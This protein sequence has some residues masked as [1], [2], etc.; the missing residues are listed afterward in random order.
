MQ[1][2]DVTPHAASNDAK[3]AGLADWDAFLDRVWLLEVSD[4]K[5]IRDVLAEGQARIAEAFRQDESIA[6]LVRARCEMVDTV[7][8]HAW[9]E[10][11]ATD[12][13]CLVAVG[14]YGRHELLP[15]SDIDLLVLYRDGQLENIGPDLEAFF[16]YLWDL[17]LQIGHSV[18]TPT[19]CRQR[20]TDD[21]TI[22]T[23]LMESRV[24]AGD[25]A[26][27]AHMR[28]ATSAEHI[29]PSADFFSAKTEEQNARHAHYDETAYKLEPNVKESPGGLRD[30]QTIAW[31]AKRQ[32]SAHTL[33]GLVD[34]GF[35]SRR[36]FS[37]LHEGQAFLWR[38]RF[39]LHLLT[40]RNE[41]RLLFD[42]QIQV[43]HL[44]GYD[45]AEN[46][47]SVERFM[48]SYY[49][50]IKSLSALN[51]V[52][53]QLF[54]EAILHADDKAYPRPLNERFQAR[55][56]FIEVVHD[57]IFVE[58]PSA[59]LEIFYLMQIHPE[60]GG[61][62]ARTLRLMRRDRH[63]IDNNFI[64][65]TNCNNLFIQIL[66]QNSGVTRALRRMNRYGILG[67]YLPN[68]GQ[69]IG[70]MQYDLLH[71][72][73]VDEHTLF[74]IRNMRR[75]ALPR[76]NH[77]MPFASTLMQSLKKPHILYIVALMHDIAKG[78][79]GD[80]AQLGA[81]D[82]KAFCAAHD[83]SPE[84]TDLIC[85]LVRQHLLMSMTAQRRD[86]SNVE[87]INQFAC[88]VGSRARLDRLYLL[89]IC[90]I[91]ATNPD[92]WNSWKDSLLTALYNNARRALD[93]GLDDPL[94]R[95]ELIAETRSA[96]AAL[97]TRNGVRTS[98]F[99]ALWERFEPE[100]FLR[101]SAD[102]IAR[103]T[104][105]I[106]EHG[107]NGPLVSIHDIPDQGTA[108]SVYCRDRN[109]LFG[110]TTGILAQLGFSIMDARINTTNDDYTLDTYIIAE[111]DGRPVEDSYRRREIESAL[112]NAIM[113]PA[114]ESIDVS[115][116]QGRRNQYFDV[117]T[118][119]HF[120]QATQHDRTVME[121][122]T[123]DRPG[124][125][126]II[127]DVFYRFGILIK[128]AKIATVGERV[129]DAFFITNSQQKALRDDGMLRELRTAIIAEL[130]RHDP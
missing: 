98:A 38:V 94:E 21:V 53:L 12:A 61:I 42:H 121:I 113:D 30:I 102:E 65:S 92:L 115:R 34:Y 7:L 125:L 14:G 70:R 58:A 62:R 55:H 5:N 60:L 109:Y 35:L 18:R 49:R 43:A 31:V 99:K 29:W 73:T 69:I 56:G 71:T 22:M 129:E 28:A 9:R 126:S 16:T 54:S 82:A 103:Q 8:T 33:D 110:V 97:L 105:A 112:I 108:L 104:R 6:R 123:A 59:L 20:A 84:D 120:T 127:G 44:L 93:R 122:F 32:F 67:R 88:E 72:L 24:L 114:V 75:L 39:A 90:D 95:H 3:A 57:N 116:R 74:V 45:D 91:R 1:L 89:T 81:Q 80:H 41:N 36:E 124:L 2:P 111:S 106:I 83:L 107:D 128:A 96:A 119:I 100:F 15:Q 40:E 27:F 26:L 77:E 50:N 85:W 17:G 25:P 51:D 118:Q 66:R 117:P 86:I 52:L 130:D 11:V 37:E 79:G 68:F 76:F 78:R 13:A 101:H 4:P 23:N 47:L 64:E 10:L 87:V 46:M 63:L 19:E 48:Q